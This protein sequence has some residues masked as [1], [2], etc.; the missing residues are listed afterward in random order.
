V[1]TVAAPGVLAND[2]DSDSPTLRATVV[3]EPANGTL[4]LQPNGAFTYTPRQGFAGT[5]RFTYRATDD[6]N[7]S[8]TATATITVA[9]VACGPRPTTHVTTTV[10]DGAL[11]V[12]VSASDVEGPS[13]NRLRELRFGEP[14]NGRIELAGQSQTA[15]FS[16]AVPTTTDR[17]S[18]AVRRV[19]PGQPTTVPLTVVD[20]CGAWPTFVGGGTGA[21]F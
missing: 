3:G 20:E 8:T 17:V 13:R 14:V 16:H 18:F 19:T 5:D 6:T 11:Q 7:L 2:T 21:G 4:A 9:P 15:A 12:T 1:L 10:A